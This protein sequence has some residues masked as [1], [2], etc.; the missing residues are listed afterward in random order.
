MGRGA[1]NAEAAGEIGGDHRVLGGAGQAVVLHIV[2]VMD[3][4]HHLPLRRGRRADDAAVHRGKAGEQGNLKGA[5]SRRFLGVVVDHQRHIGAEG[6]VGRQAVGHAGG[7]GGFHAPADPVGV[8]ADVEGDPVGVAGGGGDDAGAGGGHVHRHF[9]RAAAFNP[10][11]DA[12]IPVV[13]QAHVADV[14][15]GLERHILAAQVR[16][17][18]H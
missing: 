4:L 10:E 8:G 16:L 14:A 18:P 7:A 5:D 13:G 2:G 6:D 9:G 1:E 12:G 11:Y 15:A 17:E 3:V